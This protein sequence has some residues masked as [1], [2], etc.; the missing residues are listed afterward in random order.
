MTERKVDFLVQLPIFRDIPAA[1]L[2]RLN[3]IASEF[4]FQ[5]GAIIAYE[6][7]VAENLYIVREG[8]LEAFILD[9]NEQYIRQN[10][11]A[12]GD[13]F[14]D[15]WLFEPG[16][17]EATVRARK[18]GR[19]ILIPHQAFL[20]FVKAYPTALNA[21]YP[22]LSVMGQDA[23][24]HSRFQAYLSRGLRRRV[25]PTAEELESLLAEQ[26]IGTAD[27]SVAE[28]FDEFVPNTERIRR[29]AK[30]Q[31]LPE[32]VVYFEARRSTKIMSAQ[33]AFNLTAAVILF[34][35]PIILLG[36]SG[37]TGTIM[38]IT[39]IILGGIPLL[40][41]L[42][43][44]VN[45]LNC[46]FF[47]T[48]KRIIKYENK[49]FRFR[50]NVEKIDIQKVQSVNTETPSLLMRWLNIGTATIT[51]AAQSSVIY[52]DFIDR[53]YD[54][55]RAINTIRERNRAL[56][57]SQHRETLRKSVENFFEVEPDVVQV[58]Q[59]QRPITVQRGF[60]Q[61]LSEMFVRS[62]SNGAITYHKHPIALVRPMIFPLLT[63]ALITVAAVVL[64]YFF[65][66]IF[67]IPAVL[68][69]IIILLLADGV[70]VIWIFEDW[71]N[72]TFQVT[73]RYI[74]DIDRMPFGLRESRKQAELSKIE[75][76]SAEQE[77]L[78]PSIFKFGNVSVETAGADSN[79]VFE[80]VR[81]PERIQNEIFARRERFRQRQASVDEERQRKD[82]TILIDLYYQAVQ[83]GRIR[84]HQPLPDID[85][86][87]EGEEDPLE[88]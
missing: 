64:Y 80:N 52:F 42:V 83:Q 58:Q 43:R 67:F 24:H 78:L 26:E 29:Y 23:I 1:A 50:T 70:W 82:Y 55:E 40:N 3:G 81:E 68:G 72:D 61:R 65:Q 28:S 53:P 88:L 27:T 18:A 8:Q 66:T 63:G 38:V 77:G 20:N 75:N 79:I 36:T 49:V 34:L 30:L 51:T 46:Y 37:I 84:R 33:A 76:V 69:L 13:Y 54:V 57:E 39:G 87:E 22:H 7:D 11:Y 32:E 60:L 6:G 35:I 71:R 21:I 73:D 2:G 5:R 48:N 45:W 15:K 16:T 41:L 9:A 10:S 86:N 14:D 4:E 44:Y 31:L 56:N 25:G 19:L 17:H 47:V 74:F 12:A 59:E 62:E 85:D